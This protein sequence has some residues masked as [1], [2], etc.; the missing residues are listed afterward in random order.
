MHVSIPTML[1]E[2]LERNAQ[3]H[4][5]KTALIF[6]GHRE[7]WGGVEALANRVGHLLRHLGVARQD[8]VVLYLDNNVELC[9]SI[10]GIL[11]ADAIFSPIN[12]QTKADKLVYMLNDCR[13]RAVVTDLA[14]ASI[15][16]QVFP[17]TPH[18]KHAIVIGLEEEGLK[19]GGVE[20]V[21]FAKATAAMATTRPLA[22]NIPIDLAAIIYTSGSTGDPKG[23]M[24]THHAMVSATESITTYLENKPSDIVANLLPLSFD[25]GLYQWINVCQ[26]G[27]TLLLEQSFSYPGPILKRLVE[28]KVNGLPVVPTIASILKQYEAK[29]LKLEGIEYVTNTAAALSGSHIATL[30]SICPNARIYSMYGLTECKRV[31]YLPPSEIDKRPDSVGK[32]MPNLEVYIGDPQTGERLPPNTPG[33]LVVR[34]PQVMKGYWEK[35]EATAKRL[36]PSR[37]IPNEMHLWT[38]D[39][40]KMDE[41]GYLYFVA[42]TD[43]I[44][45]SRGEKVSPKEV[46]NMLHGIPGVV[47]AAVVGRPDEILGQ[48]VHA[49]LVL[50]EGVTMVAAQVQQTCAKKLEPFMVPKFVTFLTE[51]QKTTSNKISKTNLEAFAQ[52][53]YLAGDKPWEAPAPKKAVGTPTV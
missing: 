47:D 10:W 38:G 50:E 39:T 15:Y 52:Q 5:D 46:E 31:S 30:Q 45:K 16:E 3:R 36:K 37:E 12:A 29:G 11:R 28:E 35:P 9:A 48:A 8:R 2:Y 43:D 27:G 32:A 6:K 4:A 51:M 20:L 22:R 26:F 14:L 44:I 53:H 21:P 13:A 23:T 42:R 49:Y 34:S 24:L 41:D 19:I 33:E 1:D 40:F 25:Y 18:L 17:Q 7:S